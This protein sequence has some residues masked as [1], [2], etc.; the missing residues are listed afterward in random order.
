[1]QLIA[2][3]GTRLM[4]LSAAL[5]AARPTVGVAS[6]RNHCL[7][8]N[9]SAQLQQANLT[10]VLYEYRHLLPAHLLSKFIVAWR[11]PPK[12]AALLVP[13]RFDIPK[14]FASASVAA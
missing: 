8:L 14:S 6:K 9:Y 3:R 2:V 7:V 11:V 5:L 4:P 13:F 10:R 1:M 12:L